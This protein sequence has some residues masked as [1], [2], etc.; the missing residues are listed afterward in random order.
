MCRRYPSYTVGRLVIALLTA[1]MFGLTWWDEG[2]LSTDPDN[3]PTLAD[4]QNIL[5]VMYAGM[6]FMGTRF[7][8]RVSL[9]D[10]FA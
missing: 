5:G 4:I 7:G 1:I 10:Q 3:P 2:K 9:P 8:F 6:S